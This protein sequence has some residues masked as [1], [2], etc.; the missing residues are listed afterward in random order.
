MDN[1]NYERTMFQARISN[2]VF[3]KKWFK[4]S[5]AL[6]GKYQVYPKTFCDFGCSAGEFIEIVKKKFPTAD[7]FGA[8]VLEEPIKHLESKGFDGFVF[9]GNI[10]ASLPKKYEGKF[11][12]VSCL[13]S[14]EHVMDVDSYIQILYHSL[15]SSGLALLSSPNIVYGQYWW[16]AVKGGIPWKEGHHYRFWNLARIKQHIVLNGFKIV[17]ENHII[18]HRNWLRLSKLLVLIGLQK[19][20]GDNALARNIAIQELVFLLR[21]DDKF[22]P[23]GVAEYHHAGVD[24]PSENREY[25]KSVI[26]RELVDNKCIGH[27][28]FKLLCDI[29]G[30][31]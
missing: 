28:T 18:G 29:I 8:D 31:D 4:R 9:D 27:A 15:Q 26:S 21:K 13:A 14:I 2:R 1:K 3:N 7:V 23:I 22:T 20:R 25:M 5:L 10:K 19:N 16:H 30:N 12:V 6:M 24:V 17:D 11:D